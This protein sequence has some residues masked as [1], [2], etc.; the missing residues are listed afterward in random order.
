M[1]R[2]E[3]ILEL[4]DW[5]GSAPGRYLMAWEQDRLDQGVSDAFGFHALQ[6]GLPQLDGLRANRMPHRWVASDSLIVPEP[7]PA[8]PPRGDISTT[9][10]GDVPVQLHCEFD[11]LPFPASSLDLVLMPHTLELAREPG[12][13]ATHAEVIE[14]PAA[15]EGPQGA[16]GRVAGDHGRGAGQ[17]RVGREI[18]G[19]AD[20]AEGVEGPAHAAP[21]RGTQ[22]D[23]GGPLGRLHEGEGTDHQQHGARG[24]QAGCR[25]VV[26]Q[27]ADGVLTGEAAQT[28]GPGN[29]GGRPQVQADL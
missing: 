9:V 13:L 6:L 8:P 27:P 3:S 29:G 28:Q 14:H 5:L 7:V 12:T 4:G 22:P 1:T 21:D 11:A 10:V 16:A 15:D 2:D 19:H 26:G 23:Q 25:Q 24:E 18:V 17:G 20:H